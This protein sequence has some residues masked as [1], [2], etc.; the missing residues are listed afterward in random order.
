M[1][2]R[3]WCELAWLGGSDPPQAGV[4]IEIEGDRITSVAASKAADPEAVVL[5]GLT[6]PGL[7][8]AHSHAFQRGL[9]GR[10]EQATRGSFWTWRESMYALAD[11]LDDE[12]L[13]RLAR[14]TFAEMAL[15]GI[16]LVGEFD[17]LHRSEVILRAAAEAGVRLTLID[18]CYLEG[19]LPRFRDASARAWAQRTAALEPGPAARLAAAIHS[20]R[21]VDPDAARVVAQTAAERGWPLHAHVAEQPA[22][23]RECHERHGMSPLQLLDRAGALG[24][25]FTAVHATHFEAE[26]WALLDNSGACACLCPTTERDLADGIGRPYGRLALGS[27]SQAVIDLF[28]EARAVELDERLASGVRGIH[29]PEYLAAAATEGGYACL[30]WPEGGRIAVGALADLTTVALEDSPRLAGTRPEDALA[31]VV[32]AGVAADVTALHVGG[33]AVVRDRHHVELDVAEELAAAV[34]ALA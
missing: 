25:H 11:G 12:R 3:L 18:A 20:V 9:R 10:T 6:L 21:A 14:A 32:F 15:A 28:E 13:H 33:R 5:R 7:A 29:R 16:A 27:D 34:G 22:E 24:T 26:D 8:N 17:Y 23:V 2:Q 1:T 19:G 4:A 31:A 30:G